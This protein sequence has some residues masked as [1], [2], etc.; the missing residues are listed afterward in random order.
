MTNHLF[1]VVKGDDKLLIKILKEETKNLRGEYYAGL[2]R[3]RIDQ[4]EILKYRDFGRE[5]DIKRGY[6]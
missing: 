5:Y 2:E 3:R 6:K 1:A 4:Y